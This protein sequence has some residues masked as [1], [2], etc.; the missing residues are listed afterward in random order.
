MA[1]VPAVGTRVRVY[2]I[3]GDPNDIIAV[4]E[5]AGMLGDDYVL[6]NVTVPGEMTVHPGPLDYSKSIYAVA[7]AVG[8]R[9]SASP[10]AAA[11]EAAH[12]A[13]Y[14]IGG[15]K[16]RKARK[17]RKSRKARK[18]KKSRKQRK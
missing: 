5:F 16:S 3:A 6:H 17:A 12:A 14:L 4:G 1:Y 2:P 13:E 11:A 10:G 15:R 7:E 9:G 8:P 18:A